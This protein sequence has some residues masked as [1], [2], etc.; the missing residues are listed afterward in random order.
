[1]SSTSGG[2]ILSPNCGPWITPFRNRRIGD[3]KFARNTSR[4]L[5]F[6]GRFRSQRQ[7]QELGR[8]IVKTKA[9]EREGWDWVVGE[10][11]TIG[12]E[13][14]KLPFFI[15]DHDFSIFSQMSRRKPWLRVRKSGFH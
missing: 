6:R 3:P 10:F 15:S 9:Q 11:L 1:M 8:N 14:H 2:I 7:Q 12:N 13:T 5:R 4:Q